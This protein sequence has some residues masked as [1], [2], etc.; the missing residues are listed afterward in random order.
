VTTDRP[1]LDEFGLLRYHGQWVALT[2]TEERMLRPLL[3]S[4][5]RVV[6]TR[7]LT[8]S[9]WP[10]A[11]VRLTSL[12]TVLTR[13]RRRVRPLGLAI[14]TVRA[15]G[16]LMEPRAAHEP[17]TPTAALASSGAPHEGSSWPTS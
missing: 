2:S 17:R 8:E 5:R 12:H 7:D 16:F 15:R 14:E 3:E 13:L 10:G 9:V 11:G 1:Q 4:W 6:P